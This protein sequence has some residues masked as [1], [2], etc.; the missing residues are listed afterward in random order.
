MG[1]KRAVDKVLDVSK[2]GDRTVYTYGPLIHNPQALE[3]L[4]ERGVTAREDYDHPEKATVVIRAHG[5]SPHKKDELTSLGLEIVDATCPHVLASQ[6][7]IKRES[8]NGRMVIVV[9]DRDHA[10]VV[11]LLGHCS[12]EAV[13]V[14]TL[15]QARN[16]TLSEPVCVVAQTTFDESLFEQIADIL[17]SRAKNI[18]VVNS[19]C[20]ATYERQQEVRQL[21]NECDAVVVVGGR[22]SANTCRL[23]DIAENEGASVLH[24][25]TVHELDM[26]S[27]SQFNLIGV[28]AGASTPTWIT[29]EIIERI[30]RYGQ[31]R[32]TIA[33]LLRSIVGVISLSNLSTAAA[34][35]A[36]CYASQILQRL[37]GPYLPHAVIAFSYVFFIYTFNMARSLAEQERSNPERAAFYRSHRA[38]VWTASTPL[39]VV[40]LM[41]AFSVGPTTVLPILAFAYLLGAL[42]NTPIFKSKSSRSL[43]LKDIPAS[44]DILSALAWT[45]VTA[46]LPAI[47]SSTRQIPASL[48]IWTVVLSL[49]FLRS[50]LFDLADVQ[51]DRILG[52]ETLPTL[53]GERLTR[54]ITAL[55]LVVAAS[56]L[57][58]GGLFHVLPA[59]GLWLLL[60]LVPLAIFMILSIRGL[61]L[62]NAVAVVVVDGVIFLM[63]LIA[64]CWKLSVHGT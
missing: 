10:E 4:E 27:L 22:I 47:G 31:R 30:Q 23:V 63:G 16:V 44:K 37:P 62:S 51:S 57:F 13:V 21:A 61:L 60:A 12:G 43:S 59:L 20:K 26:E 19:I 54:W 29:Q 2:R 58:L 48:V 32:L 35:F 64:L 36:L 55:L 8:A 46:V 18:T 25:E 24:V 52:A 45:L 1:V 11:G 49:S 50:L 53:V 3:M 6:K 34:A 15:E 14:S 41:I 17:K 39:A 40:S 7:I 28:T 9:G 33:G 38:A 56:V 42:Y 5:I